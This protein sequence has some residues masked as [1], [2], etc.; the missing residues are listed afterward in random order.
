MTDIKYRRYEHVE[1]LGNRHVEG[2]DVGECYIFPKIDGTNGVIWMDDTGVIHTGS[3]NRKIAGELDDEYSDNAGFHKWV[4][5]N[6]EIFHRFIDLWDNSP[7]IMYGEWLVP[8]TIKGYRDDAWRHF[9]L[10]D[11]FHCASGRFVHYDDYSD[12]ANGSGVK[13]IEP[14]AII[15][16]PTGEQLQKQV[17][18][19]TYLLNDGA[20]LGE[21]IVIKNYGWSNMDDK[22][23][24]AKVVR[25]EFKEEN[26]R[27]F[28]VNS[29]DGT[30]QYELEFADKYVT[31]V[32][33]DKVIGKI[34][35]SVMSVDEKERLEDMIP[36]ASTE[37]FF[38]GVVENHR[39]EFIP[40]LLNTVY[41]DLV[42]EE[43][44]NFLKET[45]DPTI[46]FKKLRQFSYQFT[47]KHAKDIF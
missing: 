6:R 36:W 30:R 17:L 46:D 29:F 31:Q 18:A 7:V 47:K 25:N 42:E 45:K 10:F 21:G 43:I 33:V 15:T 27:E 38:R 16:N 13:L 2:I 41:H 24:W 37:E 26:R 44:W 14:Q 8:H 32:L 9:Y 23:P 35:L 19:N 4:T 39:A 22:Q 40:R 1:R 12:V 34:R 5:D 11:V 20:G 28:G 3:R